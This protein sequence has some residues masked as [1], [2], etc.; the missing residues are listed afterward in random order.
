MIPKAELLEMEPA[1]QLEYLR[2]YRAY[3][4][5]IASVVN[6]YSRINRAALAR[7]SLTDIDREVA[8]AVAVAYDQ[9]PAASIIVEVAS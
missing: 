3:V 5:G 1:A 7:D 4:D 8:R 9:E 2:R 6:R